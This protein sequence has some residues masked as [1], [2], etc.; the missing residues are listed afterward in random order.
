MALAFTGAG[1]AHRDAQHATR[2]ENAA[3]LVLYGEE[4]A[5]NDMAPTWV[6]VCDTEP[7]GAQRYGNVLLRDNAAT[8][9][10]AVE[11]AQV[12]QAQASPS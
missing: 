1:T 3:T 11:P 2:R 12:T 6:P 5:I 8:G 4:V 7:I 10:A 9:Q